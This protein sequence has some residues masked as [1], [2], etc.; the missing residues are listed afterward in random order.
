MELRYD[1]LRIKVDLIKNLFAQASKKLIQLIGD[2]SADVKGNDVDILLLVGGFS[3]CKVIQ[4]N[5]KASFPKKRVIVPE[6]AGL[7]VLKGAVLFGHKPEFIVSRIVRYT[8]GIAIM[9]PFNPD[10]H[11][12]HR[13]TKRGGIDKCDN[14]FFIYAKKGSVVKLGE[15]IQN[16]HNTSE[17]FM[18][19]ITFRVY[20]SPKECPMYTDEDECKLLGKVVYEIPIPSKERQV[21]ICSMVFGNTELKVTVGHKETGKEYQAVLDLI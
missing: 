7:A 14:L 13:L 19:R 3:D 5:I 2:A 12:K 1:K 17:E 10:I 9:L 16:Q 20:R 21:F 8:Y 6:D 4:E 18:K 15:K 11:D